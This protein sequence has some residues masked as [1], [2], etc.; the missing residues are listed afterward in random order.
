MTHTNLSLR[1]YSIRGENLA[2]CVGVYSPYVVYPNCGMCDFELF[3]HVFKTHKS[4]PIIRVYELAN[5]INCRHSKTVF[6]NLY[7]Y[8]LNRPN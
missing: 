4:N 6:L 3:G 8:I 7:V 5:L 2:W 1:D